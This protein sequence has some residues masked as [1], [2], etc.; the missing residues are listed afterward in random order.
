[1]YELEGGREKNYV[2]TNFL[3]FARIKLEYIWRRV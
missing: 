3:S 1:M 2:K